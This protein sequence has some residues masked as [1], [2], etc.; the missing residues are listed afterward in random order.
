MKRLSIIIPMY[1]VAPYV[2]RCIRSLEDQDIP[3]DDYEL[4]CINDGSP[5]NCGEIVTQLQHEFS[6]IVLIKQANQGVSRARNNGIEKAAGKYL[7]FIDPDDY[8]ESNSFAGILQTAEQNNVQVSFLGY[9]FL[10][11]DGTLRKAVFN[12]KEKGIVYPGLEAYF[13]AR[14][15][16]QTDPDRSW[17]VLF[18]REFM[19]KNNLRYLPN[20]PYLEDGE[21]IARIMCL[22]ERCIFDGHSFYQRTTRPGSATNS[23]LFSSK[24]A[25]NGFI[26]AAIN[27]K[28]LQASPN[29]SK[30]QKELLNQAIVKFITLAFN[31]CIGTHSYSRIISIRN[32]LRENSL[33]ECQLEGVDKSYKGYAHA[34]NYSPIILMLVLFIRRYFSLFINRLNSKYSF[35]FHVH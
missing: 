12:E 8:V 27:M 3:P 2:E 26:L 19:N 16:G 30:A 10:N 24:K 15:D 17:A 18:E 11:E 6:N 31:S 5:D 20:V 34:Y 32:K 1:N 25:T 23:K 22:A 28:K 35:L 4:I 29:L 14:G 9:S 21:L 33:G 7:L 13:V